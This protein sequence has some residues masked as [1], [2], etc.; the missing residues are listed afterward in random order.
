MVGAVVKFAIPLVY[1]GVRVRELVVISEDV[2]STR[3][4]AS[5]KGGFNGGEQWSK[6]KL[7]FLKNC[8]EDLSPLQL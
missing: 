5:G 3:F 2:E 4:K 6:V 8:C 1:G 7:G